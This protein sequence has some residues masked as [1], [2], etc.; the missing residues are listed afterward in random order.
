MIADRV[1][2][3]FPLESLKTSLT[4]EIFGGLSTIRDDA[5]LEDPDSYEGPQIGGF[6]GE[7]FTMGQLRLSSCGDVGGCC[8]SP[9]ASNSFILRLTTSF[10]NFLKLGRFPFISVD[11]C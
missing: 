3:S 1:F 7:C 6:D 8:S 10:S 11:P 9:I 5:E 2:D 4:T